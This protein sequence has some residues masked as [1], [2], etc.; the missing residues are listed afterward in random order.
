MRPIRGRFWRLSVVL[1]MLAVAS[2][3]TFRPRPPSYPV[4]LPPALETVV[5]R[6]CLEIEGAERC[7]PKGSPW[8]F[9]TIQPVLLNDENLKHYI[10]VLLTAPCLELPPS[11]E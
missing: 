3:S 10:E 6:K 8:R 4:P 9:I 5:V 7:L 2:C 11:V 1:M